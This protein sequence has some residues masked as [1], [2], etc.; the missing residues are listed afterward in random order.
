MEG[1]KGC[2]SG[3][4]LHTQPSTEELNGRREVCRV[5][6]WLHTLTALTEVENWRRKLVSWCTVNVPS[7]TQGHLRTGPEGGKGHWTSTWAYT[8]REWGMEGGTGYRQGAPQQYSQEWPGPWDQRRN[9]VWRAGRRC[10]GPL[11]K[12]RQLLPSPSSAAPGPPFLQQDAKAS[13]RF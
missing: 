6:A 9:R 11:L 3:T 2:R 7:P 13:M 1:G 12:W 5:C 8:T 4:W 10:W